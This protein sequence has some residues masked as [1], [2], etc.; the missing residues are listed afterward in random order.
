M[1]AADQQSLS[2]EFASALCAR[3]C[4]DISSPLGT[5]SGTLE[6]AAEQ[7]EE[8]EEALAIA[9]EA[10]AALVARLRL[11]RAAWAGDSGPLERS[12]IEELAGG[13]PARVRTDLA[14]LT[15]TV[16]DGQTARLLLNLVMLG[17][18]ALPAGGEVALSGGLPAGIV[19]AVSGPSVAWHAGLG[20]AMLDL[21]AAPGEPRAVQI[22]LTLR[23][24]QAAGLRLSFLLPSVPGPR[25]APRLLLAPP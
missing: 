17:A 20:P 22:P 4:H 1:P 7:P 11:L 8:A 9:G 5:L 13:L 18:E 23:L 10:A 3:L 25:G 24:V 21:A 2:L 19:L 16:F 6:L 12:Q 14:G 15:D